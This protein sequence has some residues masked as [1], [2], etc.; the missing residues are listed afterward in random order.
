MCGPAAEMT[1]EP[2]LFNKI[3]ILIRIV[4]MV[5]IRNKIAQML[6]VFITFTVMVIRRKIV[7]H[8]LPR[9]IK[10]TKPSFG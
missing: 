2:G 5:A 3:F 4:D 9:S 8:H 6:G 7:A 1:L 10:K